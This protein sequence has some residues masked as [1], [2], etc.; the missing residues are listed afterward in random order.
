[1]ARGKMDLDDCDSGAGSAPEDASDTDGDGDGDDLLGGCEQ[2][3][4]R[5]QL[6]KANIR[7]VGAGGT[8]R[9]CCQQAS[10]APPGQELAGAGVMSAAGYRPNAAANPVVTFAVGPPTHSTARSPGP[11]WKA[12]P[13]SSAWTA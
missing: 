5:T 10:R 13:S 11:R 2:D 1:M 12:Y 9:R 3:S 6:I 4:P 7:Q 8:G